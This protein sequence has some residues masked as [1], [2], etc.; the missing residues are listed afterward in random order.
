MPSTLF[1]PRMVRRSQSE[2]RVDLRRWRAWFEGE[3]GS[4]GGQGG[5]DDLGE[6]RAATLEDQQK[7]TA[8]LLK[9]LNERD[10]EKKQLQEQLTSLST[11][12]TDSEKAARKKLEEEGN[13]KALLEQTAAEK[14][15]LEPYKSRAA[16]LEEIIR[17]GNEALIARIPDDKRGIV[18]TEYPPE[19]LRLWLDTNLALLVK[20]PAPDLDA[21]AGNGGGSG[22]SMPKLSDEEKRLAAAAGMSEKDYAEMK[23]AQEKRLPVVEKASGS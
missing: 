16:E 11:R 9:R 22:A 14:A 3:G 21:G 4:G 12:M 6:Y 2:M 18:P 15:S 8:A 23:Q 17:K 5:N 20:A 1:V 19:K 10:A 7:V 13:Y